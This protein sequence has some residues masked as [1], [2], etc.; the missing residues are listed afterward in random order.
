[1]DEGADDGRLEDFAEICGIHAGDG[2][3]SSYNYEVGFGTAGTEVRY[4]WRVFL[5]YER[6]FHVGHHRIVERP[7]N[8]IVEFRIPSKRIQKKLLEVG[9]VRGPKLDDLRVPQFVMENVERQR[10]FLRGIFDTDGNFNWTMPLNQYHL[11]IS[12]TTSSEAFATDV[13]ALLRGLDYEPI[14]NI[15]PLPRTKQ[16]NLRRKATRITLQKTK[17]VKR[18]LEEIGSNNPRKI[19]FIQQRPNDLREKYG[20]AQIRTGDLIRVKDAL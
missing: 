20:P 5:L 1:M 7:K 4:F 3:M 9:F 8:N 10:R 13:V 17:D 15:L 16:G 18:F 19:S 6:F 11:R 14:T 2:W 12:L